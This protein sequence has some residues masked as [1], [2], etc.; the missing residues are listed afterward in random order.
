MGELGDNKVEE[1]VTRSGVPAEDF[2]GW[3]LVCGE[4]GDVAD[5]ADVLDG[6]IAC[7]MGEEGGIY[8]GNEGCALTLGGEVGGAEVTDGFDLGQVGDE[9]SASEL[10]AIAEGKRRAR[11]L[12]EDGLAVGT[13]EVGFWIALVDEEGGLGKGLRDRVVEVGEFCDGEGGAATDLEDFRSEFGGVGVGE[14][15]KELE[16]E[17]ELLGDVDEGGVDSVYGGAAHEADDVHGGFGVEG[18]GGGGVWGWMWVR[19]NRAA[20]IDPAQFPHSARKSW[21][22]PREGA[23]T[24]SWISWRAAGKKY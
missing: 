9:V 7:G 12:V 22:V 2:L 21:T 23:L 13:D 16:L 6:A 24:R 10:Q 14:V 8:G 20:P 17:G 15:G 19:A 11:G 1:H 3:V 18:F 5:T 4:V